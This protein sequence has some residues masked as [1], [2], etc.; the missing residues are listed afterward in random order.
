MQKEIA[1][2]MTNKSQG[3]ANSKI[4]LSSLGKYEDLNLSN[5]VEGDMDKMVFNNSE[6]GN[7]HKE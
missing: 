5:Y 6:S 3:I 1:Y 2:Q 7:V 4:F